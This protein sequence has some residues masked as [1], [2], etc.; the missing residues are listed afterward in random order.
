VSLER[1]R[2]VT[3]SLP[4]ELIRRARI[5]AAQHG[6]T[7]NALVRQLLDDAISRERRER[8]AVARLLAL[9]RRGRQSRIDPAAIKREELYKRR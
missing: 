7:V 1:K 6:T 5:Y 9:A 4:E 3:F 2:N 8:T